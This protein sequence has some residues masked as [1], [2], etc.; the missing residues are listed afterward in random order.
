MWRRTP[1]AVRR[2]FESIAWLLIGVMFL[3]TVLQSFGIISPEAE[4]AATMVKR[5]LTSHD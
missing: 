4:S 3:Y 1:V 5:V 2:L